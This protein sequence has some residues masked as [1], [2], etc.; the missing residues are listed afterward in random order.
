MSNHQRRRAHGAAMCALMAFLGSTLS[1]D[2]F[3]IREAEAACNLIPGTVRTFNSTLGATNRPFAAPNEN[4]ELR[5]RPCDVNTPGIGATPAEN[6]VTVVFTPPSGLPEAIV[7][8]SGDCTA[9][10]AELA[11]CSASLAGGTASCLPNRPIDVIDRSGVRHLRFP[12]PDTDSSILTP[13]D[14][15]TRAGPTKIAV[16]APGQPLPCGLATQTC[17][18]QVGLR[19]CIDTYFANDGA[20]GTSTPL[21]TFPSFTALPP[22]NDYQADCFADSPPCTATATEVRA[23]LDADG[24]L[25]MPVDWS[26]VLVRNGAIPVPRLMRAQIKSPVPLRLEDAVFVGS[27]TPEGGKLPPI[28]EPQKDPSV[29][30]PFVLS[31]F[32][33]ADAPYTVLRLARRHGQCS[34]G[35]RA[36][37][38]CSNDTDCPGGSCPAT[39]VGAPATTCNGDG[40]CGVDGPCGRNFDFAAIPEVP[41]GG[42]L[43]LD[44]IS[45]GGMCQ[46]DLT[47]MCVADCGF[48]GPCV[49][50][51]FEGKLPVPLDGFRAS[52]QAHSFVSLETIDG[53]DRNGDGDLNDAV[54]TF[55]DRTT[56][57][58][59]NLGIPAECGG[60]E[61]EGRSV[62]RTVDLPYRSPIVEAEADRIAFFE[63]EAYQACDVNGD[64]DQADGILRVFDLGGNELTSSISPQRVGAT[65]RSVDGGQIA[66][67]AGRVFLRSSEAGMA[68]RVSERVSV[69]PSDAQFTSVFPDCVTSNWGTYSFPVLNCTPAVSGDGR[70]I[71]FL[72]HDGSNVSRLYVRD[73]TLGTTTM[74]DQ[75]IGDIDISADGRYLGYVSTGPNSIGGRGDVI[76]HDRL[77]NSFAVITENLSAVV[78]GAVRVSDDGRYVLFYNGGLRRAD[79]CV[80]SGL[81]V[82]GCTPSTPVLDAR[83]NVLSGPP[84]LSADGRYIAA[85][86]FHNEGGTASF[87]DRFT[88]WDAE[89][90]SIAYSSWSDVPFQVPLFSADGR[91]FGGFN[92]TGFGAPNPFLRI[93]VSNW[94]TGASRVINSVTGSESDFPVVPFN[95]GNSGQVAMSR[96]ANTAL[97]MQYPQIIIRDL[98]QLTTSTLPIAYGGSAEL[99][100][101]V[102]TLALSDDGQVVVFVTASDNI[103]APG[104]DTNGGLDVFVYAAD[105]SDPLGIDSLLFANGALSDNVLEVF[106]TSNST[107]TTL[108]PAEEVAVFDGAAAFLRPESDVGTAACPG[109]S[110]NDDSDTSDLVVQLWPGSGSVLNLGRAATAVALSASHVGA[111]VSE[112]GDGVDYN[113]DGDLFDAVVQTHAENAAPGTWHN[114]A[115]AGDTLALAGDVVI[116]ATRE[117]DQGASDLNGDGDT[118]DRVLQVYDVAAQALLPCTPLSGATCTAGVRQPAAE[119]VVGEETVTHCGTLRLVAFRT[120]E[121]EAGNTD[122]NGDGDTSDGVLQVYDLVSGT[123]QNTG[124]AVTPCT[125][126][127]CDPRTP[128]KVEGGKVRF[129]TYEPDQGNQDLTGDGILG[130]ALQLY[131]FCNDVTTVI[132]AVRSGDGDS[133]PLLENQDS[134]VLTIDGNRCRF[135]IPTDCTADPCPGGSYCDAASSRCIARSPQTCANDA[136]CPAESSCVGEVVIGATAIDDYDDDGVP[137][138]Q[139]NCPTTPNTDQ[140]D[141]DGDGVGDA[142]DLQTCQNAIQETIEEC[143]DGNFVNDD[144]CTNQCRFNVCGDGFLNVGVEECDDGNTSNSDE[145][146]NDCT[147]NTC[148]DGFL[149]IGV[150]ECDDGN[151]NNEDACLVGCVANVC[152]DGF[153][154]VGVEECDDGSDND[155][156]AP[157]T[158]RTN[159]A[160]A[161]CG[162]GAIDGGEECD[163]GNLDSGDG[164]NAACVREHTGPFQPL[165]GSPGG[166]TFTE[167][168]TDFTSACTI[169]EVQVV[170]DIDHASVGN[171]TVDLSYGAVTVRLLDRPG[172]LDPDPATGG[173]AADLAGIYTFADSGAAFPQADA[174]LVQPTTYAPEGMRRAGE[175]GSLADFIG[176][177]SGGAW[178]LNVV[179]AGGGGG[180]ALHSWR[181]DA[182]LDCVQTRTYRQ[183]SGATLEDTVVSILTVPDSLAIQSVTAILEATHEAAGAIRVELAHDS[184][185]GLLLNQQGGYENGIWTDDDL[186][187][188]YAFRDGAGPPIWDLPGDVPVPPGL[189]APEGSLREFVGV[190]AAGDWTLTIETRWWGQ[191]GTLH[192]WGV[193]VTGVASQRATVAAG[194]VSVCGDGYQASDEVCDDGNLVDGDGCTRRCTISSREFGKCQAAVGKANASYITTRLKLLQRCRNDLNK[195]KR[196]Y[197]DRAGTAQVSSPRDCAGEFKTAAKL[198]KLTGSLHGK[199]AKAC[200]DNLVGQLRACASTVDG[201]I[202]ATGTSGCMLIEND[203]VVDGWI[204]DQFGRLLDPAEKAEYACQARIA[205]AAGRYVKVRT[206]VLQKCRNALATGKTPYA[207]KAKTLPIVDPAQCFAEVKASAALTKA[208][209]KLRQAIAGS[210]RCSDPLAASLATACATTIDELVNESGDGGCLVVGLGTGVDRSIATGY[211][212]A[213]TDG[214]GWSDALDNCPNVYN[215]D[216]ADADGDGIADACDNCPAIANADQADVDGDGRGDA[217]DPDIDGDGI[218][219][220]ADNCPTTYNPDQA[221]VADFLMIMVDGDSLDEYEPGVV[222]YP[223]FETA[224]GPLMMDNLAFACGTCADAEFNDSVVQLGGFNT[225]CNRASGLMRHLATSGQPLC[226]RSS[227]SGKKYEFVLRS[228]ADR[229]NNNCYGPGCTLAGEKTSYIRSDGVGDACAP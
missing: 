48:D 16:S 49:N 172:V 189:Y 63:S 12:F 137:N 59:Q 216:Q 7:L 181:V 207:D 96:D 156:V 142:C 153:L 218:Y 15:I 30:D 14:D 113:G 141:L 158:C 206:G 36:G 71:A 76:V 58:A 174:P 208:G 202:S 159:C 160:A 180:G 89:T 200:S 118:S 132:G 46:E 191:T 107:I 217:C 33:S 209:V 56:G 123:L 183:T 165:P 78:E 219:N 146:L 54:V 213:D 128:F 22:P 196:L 18:A 99:N 95:Q 13:F 102:R 164:C 31:L 86:S 125:I 29:S 74:I 5:L 91:I 173:S 134:L 77:E 110:L 24:N 57:R 112:A 73:R 90:A 100:A 23:A 39:C 53:V 35:A 81:A 114:T 103:L 199:L 129:L 167:V 25:L 50:Y 120:S 34:A 84:K 67:S 198:T 184:A 140:A 83:F 195:G 106:D 197:F 28:F 55:R 1:H 40:D 151:D 47:Q 117:T 145:C 227:S 62:M 131:D 8:T 32:G 116:F 119:F 162:D 188:E 226:G 221:D 17:G 45:A 61:A 122:L 166:F 194:P 186:V 176:L 101:E 148:G 133:D 98:R 175:G 204:D 187:G 41:S 121:A 42:A 201:L 224:Q 51:A 111:L 136:D 169:N 215:P 185:S 3:G 144:E 192:S 20:C 9:I 157:N 68:A 152:G 79:R 10:N 92:F 97:F 229:G 94:E 4:V 168:R 60:G 182:T 177:E 154:N 2:R 225:L 190:D 203:A 149:H 228:F 171:L 80:A 37:L 105:P 64:G 155:D 27:Y 143:D 69:D 126:P 75:A 205:N 66:F 65:A 52:Q 210:G 150:E 223:Y 163:D 161:A 170:F 11:A 214:D 130:L 127:E 44:R 88:L 178:T 222:M 109:G 43:V 93:Q 72:A 212:F 26:G 115:Q 104:E 193:E 135:A 38:A 138:D 139:D 211:G 82:P 147:L 6:I 21:A 87:S 85:V 108:C 179:D 124:A 70:Y 220:A 19:A